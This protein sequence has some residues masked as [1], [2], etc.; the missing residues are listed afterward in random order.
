MRIL[1]LTDFYP[2]HIGGLE[3]H[4]HMIA[5]E[6]AR[7]DHKVSVATIWHEGLPYFEQ[8]DGVNV[9]RMVGLVHKLTGLYSDTQRR[10]HPTAPDPLLVRA[11]RKIIRQ[12]KPQIVVASGWILYSYLPLK[13]RSPAKLFVRHHDYAFVCPKRT[14]LYMDGQ[15]CS[16]PGFYKCFPCCGAHYGALKGTFIN[17]AFRL[18]RRLHGRVDYHLP[19]SS[20]VSQAVN[21]TNEIPPDAVRVVPAPVPDEIFESAPAPSCPAGIPEDEHF[22]LYVG[23][24]SK[25]KGLEVLL[26]AYRGMEEQAKLL[27]IGT[28]W[29]DSPT[30][31]PEGVSVIQN[32]PHA[33][34]ME[35]FA[36]CVFSV[37]PSIW[38]EPFGQVAVEAMA[39]RKPV[40]AS[41]HGGL[42]DIVVDGETG[43]LIEPGS[44]PALRQAMLRLLEAETLRRTY[45]SAG[46]AR[47]SEHFTRTQ[48]TNQIEAIFNEQLQLKDENPSRGT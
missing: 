17:G 3:R 21:L 26:D 23:A 27:L 5:S 25:H 46:Y 30:S 8:V 18:S 48:V 19:I 22:I 31:F 44:A 32:A 2:P 12:E 11:L 47:A 36:R 24:L 34:V 4:V 9:Y 1:W 37:V 33:T 6:L 15:I 42:T 45:G 29:P 20:Y 35:A 39:A 38:P 13:T 14:L 41:A 40:I 10:F 7:R 43:I 28:T 16:G